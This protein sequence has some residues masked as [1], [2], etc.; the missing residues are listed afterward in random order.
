MSRFDSLAEHHQQK[1]LRSLPRYD[2]IE[3][4]DPEPAKDEWKGVI[5]ALMILAAAAGYAWGKF[6]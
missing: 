6:L 1:S 2:A 4:H 3:R 5:V